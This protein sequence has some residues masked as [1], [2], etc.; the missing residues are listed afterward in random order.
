MFSSLAFN[1]IA[2]P[3]RLGTSSLLVLVG[4]IFL[5][6]LV[7]GCGGGDKTENTASE[8]VVLA[9][10][11]NEDITSDYYEG[12][13]VLLEEKELPRENGVSMDM[14]SE[15]GKMAFLNILINKELMYQ[16]AVQ[17]GYD[18]DPKIEQLRKT[19]SNYEGGLVMWDEAVEEVAN[20]ITEDELQD[21]YKHMGE[22][23]RC[24]YIIC[25]F[26]DDALEA[27]EYAMSGATWE[28]VTSKYHDGEVPKRGFLELKFTYGQYA[29]EFEDG[30]IGT[31]VGDVTQPISSTYGYWVL[32]PVEITQGD[33]PDLDKSKDEILTVTRNRKIGKSQ[34]AF[35]K[36]V[37]DEYKFIINEDALWIAY[38]GVPDNEL[39]D[40]ETKKP[41]TKDQL[42]P[43]SL[44]PEDLGLLLYSF[45]E[46]GGELTE[47]VLGDYKTHFDKMSVFQRPKRSEMLGG[48]RMKLISEVER[49]L[50]AME[51]KRRGYYEH[52]TVKLKVQKKMEEMIVTNLYNDVV[53]FD[54]KISPEQFNEFWEAHKSDYKAPE[55]RSGHLVICLSRD[56]ADQARKAIMDGMEWSEVLT[57]F[58][59]DPNNKSVGGK[60]GAVAE[61]QSPFSGP[62][63][64]LEKNGV[65]QPFLLKEGYWAVV[66]LENINPAH[67]YEVNEVNEAIGQRMR[68]E[69]REEAFSQL[70]EQWTE[71]FGVEIFSENLSGLKSWR[72]LQGLVTPE[73]METEH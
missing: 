50:L 55:T 4:A 3:R 6:L 40:P 9:K 45:Q 58:G 52:P 2:K 37:R 35:K 63:F 23:Y 73:K 54:D 39:M 17:L 13:L 62:L 31:A 16:K 57:Q 33:K 24:R 34:N 65:S 59:N 46:P 66:R 19:M 48:F 68:N 60:T 36:S 20:T 32:K 47:M 44:K 26:L 53:T 1:P 30:V 43:L 56:K 72:E 29:A 67:D 51:T 8:S 70:L 49:S 10:V 22:K 12:R 71:E 14:G 27:R 15:A 7:A 21:Y 69:R 11:G 41:Y 18:K 64:S 28:D 61:G 5:A 42:E 38:Q 25:N